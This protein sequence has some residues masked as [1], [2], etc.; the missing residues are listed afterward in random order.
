MRSAGVT[1]IQVSMGYIRRPVSKTERQKQDEAGEEDDVGE[2]GRKRKRDREQERK[3]LKL[4][5]KLN[6]REYQQQQQPPT[7]TPSLLSNVG[8]E[9]SDT[10][11]IFPVIQ[12]FN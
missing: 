12:K 10:R 5:I 4:H 2:E 11:K 7:P 6:G 9:K 3:K 8:R 1:Q